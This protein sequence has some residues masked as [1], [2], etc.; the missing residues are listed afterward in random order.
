M[1]NNIEKIIENL[2]MHNYTTHN[3]NFISENRKK[4]EILE[5]FSNKNQ[6]VKDELINLILNLMNSIIG[7]KSVAINLKNDLKN[8]I[9]NFNL[10]GS[11]NSD[12]EQFIQS[13]SNYKKLKT[14]TIDAAK[15]INSL[16]NNNNVN[17]LT[18]EIIKSKVNNPI[19]FIKNISTLSP[20]HIN[21][22][23][24]QFN[25]KK[26]KD[27][28]LN[29]DI[30]IKKSIVFFIFNE[31]NNA[32]INHNFH[33]FEEIK[34][35]EKI[36]TLLKREIPKINQKFNS[37]I[38]FTNDQILHFVSLNKNQ[39]LDNL[40]SALFDFFSYLNKHNISNLNI[41]AFNN[42]DSENIYKEQ[43][44]NE[45][46]IQKPGL[47]NIIGVSPFYNKAFISKIITQFS[48][49]ND[50]MI[51]MKSNDDM[52]LSVKIAKE[53]AY[54]Y[55]KANNPSEI[56]HHINKGFCISTNDINSQISGN[57]AGISLTTAIISKILNIKI[58]D[59][60]AFTGAISLEGCIKAVGA[61]DLKLIKCSNSG[62]KKVFI[63][64]ENE[65]DYLKISS[66][67]NPEMNVILINTYDEIF[68]DLFLNK[69][70]MLIK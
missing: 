6:N 3:P 60:T 43:N 7:F 57:S 36:E 4:I 16:N 55:L 44:N 42:W 12:I 28:Y 58:P 5:S 34:F 68:N 26:I 19:I 40:K 9:T 53:V 54:E 64:K 31:Y 2:I 8:D 13:I 29:L 38:Q 63:P 11:K 46:N 65:N 33:M 41:E 56:K 61:I 23:F 22:I 67:L 39:C 52:N 25:T 17:L 27:Q 32:L 48:S 21:F 30:N 50:D 35:N 49:S 59:D 70:K 14:I 24:N 15:F 69:N 62:I 45:S 47:V 1:K 10:I 66:Y 20:E 18:S 51:L 37:N